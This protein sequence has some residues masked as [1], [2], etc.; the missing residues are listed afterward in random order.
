M[1]AGSDARWLALSGPDAR[2]ADV[3]AAIRAALEELPG[4]SVSVFDRDLRYLLVRGTALAS[5]GLTAGKL[6][7]GRAPDVLEPDVWEFYRP[8]YE[9]ALGGERTKADLSSRDGLRHYVV[10]VGPVRADG[11]AVVGGIAIASDITDEWTARA[12][13]AKSKE[14]YRLLVENSS[15][16]VMRT[17]PDGVIEW[18]SDSLTDV[19]GWEP[20]E[21]VGLR[22]LDFAHPDAVESVTSATALV[23]LGATVSGRLQV[24]AKDDSYR[25]M[26]RTLRPLC[27]DDGSVIARVSG[28]RDVQ[29]EVEA[30][31]ARAAS[32]EIFR[33]AMDSSAIGMF[34]G[35]VE[36]RFVRVNPAMCRML[37][38]SADDLTS[39]TFWDVTHPDDRAAAEVGL[40]AVFTGEVSVARVRKRY[41]ARSGA[42][43]W[44]DMTA[45]LVPARDDRPAQ[46]IGQSVDVSA[47]VANSQALQRAADEF[48]M[49]AE[50]ATDVVYRVSIAGDFEWVSP[51]MFTV[52]GW[53]PSTLIGT[54]SIALLEPDDRDLVLQRRAEFAAG[55][56]GP[57]L[58]LRFRTSSGA[59]REMSAA[60]HPIFDEGAAH[61]GTV[62]GLRDVTEEQRIRREL[63][64]R[65]SHDSLTGVANRDDLMSRLRRRLELPAEP[66]RAAGVLFCDVDNLKS[67]NDA[68]GHPT[69]DTV[70]STVAERLV[71]IV[72][73]HDVVARLGGDEFVVVVTDVES[74][75]QLSQIAEKCRH[76]VAA[77]MQIGGRTLEVTISMG[78][79]LAEANE[80]PDDVLKRADGAVYRAKQAGRNRVVIGDA[81]L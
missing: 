38:Y 32:E 50:N 58:L 8:L 27:A 20:D 15:D 18:V 23:D 17:T 72:R 65:A 76:A 77:P 68:Y 21:V 63:A 30:E 14:R 22:S 79:V 29:Q 62:I 45:V 55:L 35:T 1:A 42:I 46:V 34:F 31:Q 51:S 12:D 40:A 56:N 74:L 60:T 43:V 47:E 49:L 33:L 41:V 19:L 53:E 66:E 59:V 36:G 10:R 48:Q 71:G 37:G 4:S 78:G 26:S 7:G 16:F 80:E 13:L 61:V 9:A 2:Q 57:A 25:W 28:W 24:R 69:G 11:G 52:L 6:E 73:S 39:M 3:A 54:P 64:Y 67:V 44:A 5:G 81:S 75:E 70:L